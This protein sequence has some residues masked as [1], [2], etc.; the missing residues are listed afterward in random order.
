M[1]L[2]RRQL[3]VRKGACPRASANGA[4]GYFTFQSRSINQA[5]EVPILRM[6]FL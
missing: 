6:L 1:F 2:N 5:S 3:E 4:I